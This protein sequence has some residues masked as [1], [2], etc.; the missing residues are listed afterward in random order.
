MPP[1]VENVFVIDAYATPAA[2]AYLHV[3]ASFVVSDKVADAVPAGSVP[4]GMPFVRVGGCVSVAVTVTV[5]DLVTEPAA[6]VAVSVYA[7][8]SVGDTALEPDA[9]T[10]PM[11]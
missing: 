1:V 10:V 9:A 3:A 4:A 11:P 6:L 7:V 8:V 5:A 2:V